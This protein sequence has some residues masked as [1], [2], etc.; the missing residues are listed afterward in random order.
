MHILLKYSVVQQYYKKTMLQSSG[1]TFSVYIAVSDIIWT[2]EREC[3]AISTLWTFILLTTI[4]VAQQYTGKTM[5]HFHGDSYANAQQC[6]IIYTCLCFCIIP[7]LISH[8][9]QSLSLPICSPDSLS[10][11]VVYHDRFNVISP[12]QQP[13]SGIVPKTDHECF[14]PHSFSFIMNMTWPMT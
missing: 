13:R 4:N 8:P 1:N 2:K 3:I 7:D 12:S 10:S 9:S 11:T 14:L 6:Y 5:F